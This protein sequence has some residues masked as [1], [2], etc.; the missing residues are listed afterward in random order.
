VQIIDNKALL[1]TAPN[2]HTIPHYI[3]KSAVVE[4]GDH[5]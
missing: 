3:T 1:I 2:A 5:A 4:G